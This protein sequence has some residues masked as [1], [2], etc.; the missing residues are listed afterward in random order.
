LTLGF[1]LENDD[2][3]INNAKSVIKFGGMDK[4]GL[5]DDS[6]KSNGKTTLRRFRT[7]NKTTWDIGL[8]YAKVGTSFLGKTLTVRMEP[9]LPYIYLPSDMYKT[10]S[11]YVNSRYA[12]VYDNPVCNFSEKGCM[13]PVTC[14]KVT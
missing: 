6:T 13:F 2:I 9:Q 10:F 11:D 3:K 5:K 4:Q 14:D 8:E 7:K 1:Y 12:T